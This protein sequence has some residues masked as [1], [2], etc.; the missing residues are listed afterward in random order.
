[1][2]RRPAAESAFSAHV[3]YHVSLPWFSCTKAHLAPASWNADMT[4]STVSL[5]KN[6]SL[7]HKIC[8]MPFLKPTGTFGPCATPRPHTQR[9]PLRSGCQGGR[10]PLEPSRNTSLL[11]GVDASRGQAPLGRA[12]LFLRGLLLLLLLLLAGYERAPSSC[13]A[14]G[15]TQQP[16]TQQ[17][18]NEQGHV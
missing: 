5:F 6:W 10:G 9:G 16:S 13:A 7:L 11:A 2:T 1:M 18:D 15:P 4:R 14:E 12:W 8:Q 3:G 17:T